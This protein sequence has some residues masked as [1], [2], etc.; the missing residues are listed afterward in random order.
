MNPASVWPHFPVITLKLVT[1]ICIHLEDETDLFQTGTKFYFSPSPIFLIPY[2]ERPAWISFTRTAGV[3]EWRGGVCAEVETENM[4][5]L[6]SSGPGP[7]PGQVQVRW[8]SGRSFELDTNASQACL[9]T[10]ALSHD[11]DLKKGTKKRLMYY[12][13]P[14]HIDTGNYCQNLKRWGK[15]VFWYFSPLKSVF[16]HL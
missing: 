3:W 15:I 11:Q 12:W 13:P 8:G 2:H 4:D 14:C 16:C 7:G 10:P 5:P 1:A 9:L 6:S